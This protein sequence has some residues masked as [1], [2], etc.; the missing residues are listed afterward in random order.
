MCQAQFIDPALKG[1][2]NLLQSAAKA[3]SVKRVVLTASA[4]SVLF[5]GRSRE[6]V[7]VDE[8]WWSDPDWC[9]ERKVHRKTS[10][11]A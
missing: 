9:R 8:S 10:F 7:V 11:H 2:M 5:N 6:G 1:T 4:A 3:K